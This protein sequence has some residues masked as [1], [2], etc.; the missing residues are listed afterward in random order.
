MGAA[1]TGWGKGGEWV[2]NVIGT[3]EVFLVVNLLRSRRSRWL[4]VVEMVVGALFL[5]SECARGLCYHHGLSF[6]FPHAL[7]AST[8]I[9]TLF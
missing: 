7:F 2:P 9:D 3:F 4:D 6:S 1:V 8:L 5:A